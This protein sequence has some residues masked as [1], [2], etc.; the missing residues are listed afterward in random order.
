MKKAGEAIEKALW[1]RVTGLRPKKNR[2]GA[3]E[4]IGLMMGNKKL[5]HNQE[6][7]VEIDRCAYL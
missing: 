7:Q 4:C 5:W 3:V 6:P 2:R 1:L